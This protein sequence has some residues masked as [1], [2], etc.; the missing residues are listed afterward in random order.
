MSSNKEKGLDFYGS[1]LL[2][3]IGAISTLYSGF[4]LREA[5]NDIKDFEHAYSLTVRR[6]FL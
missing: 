6:C 1:L 4:K 2:A 5:N 3:S